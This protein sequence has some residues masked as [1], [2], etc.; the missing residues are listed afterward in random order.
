M[1]P[2]TTAWL[3]WPCIVALPVWLASMGAHERLFPASW[4]QDNAY[5]AG[6]PSPL[7]LLLGLTSVAC[8]MFFVVLY[9]W[10]HVRGI[11]G[12]T[13]TP[14]QRNGYAPY[15]FWV[16][17]RTHLSQPEGFVML[18]GYLGGTWM[19][20]LMPQSYYNYEGGINWLHV[21]LQLLLQDFV[22]F[23]MHLGEHKISAAFY[24]S[25]HK[26]HHRFTSPRLFD[27]FDG[28]PADTLC[29]ILIPLYVTALAVPANVWSYMTFGSLYANWLTLIHSEFHHPWDP[30]FQSLGLGS[31]ADHHVHHKLFVWNFGHLF[32]Y[33]DRLLGSYRHP[34]GVK[35]FTLSSL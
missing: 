7:G 3:L 30:V 19:L 17:L 35:H 8:G 9:H 2:R 22:Q 23:L 34:R 11:L 10:A 15:S 21:A 31:A 24:R 28:S 5:F 25:S 1:L 13:P 16:G 27:A 33:W 29:M 14:V 12:G 20:G 4:W 18:G 26:P 6:C 32:S